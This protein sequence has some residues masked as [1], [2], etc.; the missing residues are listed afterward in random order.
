[1]KISVN[2]L[3]Q[4]TDIKCTVDELV[5]KIG[6]QL[7][8]VE[9]V[10]SLEK[11]Y[12]DIV[13]AKVISCEKHPDADK[14][15]VCK[16][17]DG[18]KTAGV[19]RDENG[20]V[21]VV[22]GAPNVREGLLVAWIP[23]G[24]IVPSTYDTEQFK[25]EVRPLR[26]VDS[27]GMLASGKELA[28]NEDHEGILEVDIDC[29]PGTSLIK[30]Y[31][32][33]DYIIDIENKMFTHRPDC[34]GILGV[35]REIAGIQH[36][37][38]TSPEWYKEALAY[39]PMGKKLKL[40]V[41]NDIPDLV[42]RFMMVPIS[43]VNVAPSP[44]YIQSYLNRVGI[45]PINNIVD[46]T[47]Y[48]MY[49]TGQPLHAFDYDKVAAQDNGDTA[50]IV[51]RKPKK[52]EKITLIK[53]RTIEPGKDT[54]MI[55]S[56]DRLLAVGGVMGGADTEI[57]A[58]TT[59]IILECATFDMY[60][61][62]RTSMAH[63]L[64]TD[65]VT[66]FNKG[67]SPLQNDKVLAYAGRLMCDLGGGEFA[68]DV[69]DI[70]IKKF[71]E[72]TV[73]LTANFVNER[74][75]EKLVI[76]DMAK[77]LENVEFEAKHSD[78]KLSVTPPF[79]RT[80]IEI[81]E[82]VVEEV[83]RLYGYDHLPQELPQRRVT[84]A[85]KDS[86]LECKATVR[87]ILSAAGA[88][89]VL[90]YSFVHGDLIDKVG[91]DRKNAF[92]ISNA[93]SPDLQYYRL[94][95][96]PSL[97]DKVH[98]NIRAGHSEFAIFEMNPVHGK[99]LIGK[100]KLPTEDYRVALVFAADEKATNANYKG[101]PYYQA[102]AFADQLLEELGIVATYES[103]AS[104]NP[105]QPIS[106]AAIAP[107]EKDRTAIVRAATGEF[108]G[109][110]GE[111]RS[112]VRKR[113]K[114]PEFVA[115][116]ELDLRQ[117][118]ALAKPRAYQPLSRFPSTEQDISFKLPTSVSYQKL[119][120]LVYGELVSAQQEHGYDAALSP[121]DIYQPSDD[122]AH[123]HI[124]LRIKLTHDARTLTRAEVTKLLDAITAIA[125]TKLDAVRL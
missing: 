15:S 12:K 28:L 29:T 124:T 38:F 64:F 5:T 86:L 122:H 34:F 2:W 37:Q 50:T 95:L 18:G 84:P 71:K 110:I 40:N 61:I 89:E 59:N 21:Q 47:N 105:K 63:G 23:P 90:T 103:A 125:Q 14:L 24:A 91:Q 69:H 99:D 11:R 81:P 96:L 114:L 33:D 117:L 60:N 85:Q 121:V 100:D 48:V 83:G 56:K 39:T 6:A 77:M 79:W 116:F 62:R 7:G 119:F 67:Q 118:L 31:E 20:W 66:R 53:G 101:A 17:D 26:G 41:T 35:A 58:D 107:F 98:A 22:C 57:D 82:D 93:L 94:S 87:D 108:I 43:G 106:K 55:A 10:I 27:N 75:G 68:G 80:D 54:I 111:F 36:I 88:N 72:P 16:V 109:E 3:K 32:L 113:L 49:V 25:L 52:G 65:A 97:L 8:E 115:G 42:P 30:A 123:K 112:I 1:M 44:T 120:E 19:A 9:E 73:E 51:V 78:N 46:I 70:N 74:L 76:T 13:I 4:F 102:R 92:Q 45:N 104:H